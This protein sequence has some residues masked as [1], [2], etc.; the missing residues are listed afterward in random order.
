MGVPPW[1]FTTIVPSQELLHKG[2]VDVTDCHVIKVGLMIL[3]RDVRVQF[4]ESRTVTVYDPAGKFAHPP[5]A[6]FIT[7]PG[8]GEIENK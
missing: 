5:F 3:Y 1:A 8:K 4:H 2:A 6:K 7:P